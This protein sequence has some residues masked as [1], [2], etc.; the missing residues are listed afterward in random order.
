MT[1]AKREKIYRGFSFIFGAGII[2]ISYYIGEFLSY[3][4]AGFISPAVMG[5]LVLFALLKAGIIE[6]AWVE[7]A[8]NFLLDNLMLFFIPAT[9]GVALVPFITIKDQAAA[10]LISVIISSF[11]VLWIV[12]YIIE[13]FENTK[14]TN[15]NLL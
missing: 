7:I 3:L 5:M 12:G 14:L 13:K 4:I 9:A 1:F 8:S 10:I 11:L 2:V 15:D 6:P